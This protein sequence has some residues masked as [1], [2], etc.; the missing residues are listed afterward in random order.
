MLLCDE[1]VKLGLYLPTTTTAINQ[2]RSPTIFLHT[3]KKQEIRPLALKLEKKVGISK[4]RQKMQKI[5]K[6][7]IYLYIYSQKKINYK[8]PFE[9]KKSRDDL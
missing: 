1:R 3:H 2:S 4:K 5:Q 8:F 9:N 7:E 6:A